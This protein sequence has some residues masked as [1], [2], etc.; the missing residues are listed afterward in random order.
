MFMKKSGAWWSQR[1][2]VEENY[3]KAFYVNDSSIQIKKELSMPQEKHTFFPGNE[4]PRNRLELFP[5]FLIRADS[6]LRT[7]WDS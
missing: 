1:C 3:N 7:V 6:R 4:I 2:L 5:K